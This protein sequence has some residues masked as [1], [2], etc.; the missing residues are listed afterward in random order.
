MGLHTTT[1][2]LL[3]IRGN[4]LVLNHILG[5]RETLSVPLSGA[6]VRQRRLVGLGVVAVADVGAR[7]PLL[8]VWQRAAV[9]AQERFVFLRFPCGKL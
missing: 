4:P 8:L 6:I 2:S 7:D 5:R 1:Q 3:D 9:E